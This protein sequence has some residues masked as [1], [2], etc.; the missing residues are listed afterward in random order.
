METKQTILSD[1]AYLTIDVP[2]H[3]MPFLTYLSECQSKGLNFDV[4]GPQNIVTSVLNNLGKNH[5]GFDELSFGKGPVHPALFKSTYQSFLQTIPAIEAIWEEN[6]KKPKLLIADI[7]ATYAKSLATKHKIPLLV[8]F[9]SY[10]V[11]NVTGDWQQHVEKATL[12]ERDESLVPLQ[13]EVEDKYGVSIKSMRDIII[14]GDHNISCISK[15]IGDLVTLEKENCT[16]V[17]PALRDESKCEIPGID[18]AFL[19][20]N[21]LIYVSLG[22][23]QPNMAGFSCYESIIE[24]LKDTEHKVLIGATQGKAEELIA[25]GLPKNIIVKNWV[26]QTKVLEHSKLF[27]SHVGAG[28]MMEALSTGVP[29]IAIPNFADQPINAGVVEKL[30]TGRWLKDK[31]PESIKKLVEEVLANENI[32][33][34]CQKYQKIIN[35][36]ASSGKEMF[37]E[38]VK[39]LMK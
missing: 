9:G 34:N 32:K 22:T 4:Y 1:I 2:S 12:V 16:Y 11:Q 26:P 8:L 33:S 28:G 14:E 27:I 31:S 37:I 15:F 19:K 29:V 30:N 39:S 38:I 23:A 25:K 13:K 17:G 36:E 35:S 5:F 20:D 3:I 18:S 6:K 7:F 10:F 21:D 24:A